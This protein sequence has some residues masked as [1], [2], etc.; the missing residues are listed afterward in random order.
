VQILDHIEAVYNGTKTLSARFEQA[1]KNR[2]FRRT[3]YSRGQVRFSQPGLME[4]RYERPAK[5]RFVLDGKDLWIHQLDDGQ[6]FVRRGYDGDD[7]KAAL[8]FLWG[9][10]KLRAEHTVTL[11][12]RGSGRVLLKL[13][14]KKPAGFYD[15]M[16]LAVDMRTFRITHTVVVDQR[17][18]ENRFAF[19]D[20]VYNAVMPASSFRFTV[21]AGSSVTELAGQ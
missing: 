9:D 13:Q 11:L 4:W 15:H 20:V 12:K 7:L 16:R 21:P 6:V 17:G 3:Q 1:F 14:P 19:K 2:V 8:R 5:R 18:N 10:G